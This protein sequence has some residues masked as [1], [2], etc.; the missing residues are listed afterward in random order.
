MGR[1]DAGG[2]LTARASMTSLQWSPGDRIRFTIR[3]GLVV[4]AIDPCGQRDLGENGLLR[5]PV[6]IRRACHL[7][8]GDQI[9]LAALPAR[10]RLIIHPPAT[11]ATLT[12]ALHDTATGGDRR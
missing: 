2:R 1:L 5:L 8:A 6:A 11:L 10:Q 12:A 7:R 3:D 9:L 4:A